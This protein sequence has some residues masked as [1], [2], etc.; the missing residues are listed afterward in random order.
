MLMNGDGRPWYSD[1]LLWAAGLSS[2][3]YF[4]LST[5][6]A[7]RI[8]SSDLNSSARGYFYGAL[9]TTVLL[10]VVALIVAVANR[11]DAAAGVPVLVSALFGSFV[12]IVF[13]GP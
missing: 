7:L 1:P 10:Y 13:Y 12:C 2:L 11:H 3:L 9:G 6:F 5:R 8:E 4:V